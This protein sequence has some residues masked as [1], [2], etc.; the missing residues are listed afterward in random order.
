[1]LLNV[2]IHYFLFQLVALQ[3]GYSPEDK[4]LSTDGFLEVQGLDIL[5]HL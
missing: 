2:E 1:M 3:I 5:F 4:M